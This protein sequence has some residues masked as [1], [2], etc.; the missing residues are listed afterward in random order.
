M[1]ARGGDGAQARFLRGRLL[2]QKARVAGSRPGPG[3]LACSRADGS[4]GGRHRRVRP[5]AGPRCHNPPRE[6][7]GLSPRTP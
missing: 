6:V 7:P 5:G 4:A 3:P 1:W 2:L